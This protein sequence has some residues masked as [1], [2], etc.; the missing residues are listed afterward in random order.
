[1]LEVSK[2]EQARSTLSYRFSSVRRS[3]HLIATSIGA[4]LV[5]LV[6]LLGFQTYVPVEYI[7]RDP[8]AIAEHPIYYGAVSNLGILLWSASVTACLL[9]GTIVKVLKDKTE[10]VS[11]FLAFGS[12]SLF[13][14]MDDLFLLH[15]D[16]FPRRLNLPEEITFVVYA[17]AVSAALVRFRKFL[18]K[19]Q[20]ALFG[21]AL[22]LFAFSLS[23][24]L[25]FSLF[26]L[27][28]G[29]AYAIEDG[30]KFI[31]IFV[32]CMYFLWAAIDQITTASIVK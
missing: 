9:G 11:F 12:L 10:A 15:E 16:L 14:C 3:Y 7:T 21:A 6:V 30:F 25:I 1:M 2:I 4:L 5:G 26:E 24:D 18:L 22:L 17:I 32:W 23:S 19:N 13:L 29:A 8:A 28:G 27:E 20:P 31:A